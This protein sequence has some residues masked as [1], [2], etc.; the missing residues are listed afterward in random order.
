MQPIYFIPSEDEYL[1]R[2]DHKGYKK[3][4]KEIFRQSAFGRVAS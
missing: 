3:L 1:Y 2:N 4:F